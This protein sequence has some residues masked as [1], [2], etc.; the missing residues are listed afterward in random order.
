MPIR[1]KMPNIA[2]VCAVNRKIKHNL[3]A[4]CP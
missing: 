3:A 2:P 4:T 1:L